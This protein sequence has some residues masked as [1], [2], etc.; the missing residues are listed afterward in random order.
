MRKWILPDTCN[1]L[2]RRLR[3]KKDNYCLEF[4][5]RKF[6]LQYKVKNVADLLVIIITASF[7]LGYIF[8]FFLRI[9]FVQKVNN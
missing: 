4:G 7:Q 9:K 5:S 1:A 6:K 8:L 2:N 3:I